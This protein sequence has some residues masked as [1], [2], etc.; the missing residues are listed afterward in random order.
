VRDKKPIAVDKIRS[1]GV[2][3]EVFYDFRNHNFFFECPG[4]RDRES[5][6]TFVEVCRRLYEV[7]EKAEPLCWTPV[8]LVTLHKAYDEEDHPVRSKPVEGAS[9]S[10]RFR[11]CELSPRPDHTEVVERIASERERDDRLGRHRSD[12]GPIE[13]EG[14]LE[15]EHAIDFEARDPSDYDREVRAKALDRPST[16]DND[17]DDVELPYDEDTWRGL[18]ALKVAIDELHA[19][20]KMLIGL[21]DFRDRLK[22]F[23]RGTPIPLLQE[24][25]RG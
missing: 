21:A 8:I 10:L 22:R 19:K 2:D 1:G 23:A 14:Y 15:R 7:Y 25:A 5:A 20:V 4:T 13:R 3:V 16:Y 11:R 17:E 18:C 9:V 24:V 6:E 12:R